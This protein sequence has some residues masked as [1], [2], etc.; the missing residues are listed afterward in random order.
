MS[1]ERTGELYEIFEGLPRVPRQTSPTSDKDTLPFYSLL[2]VLKP[3]FH[4]LETISREIRRAQRHVDSCVDE[5]HRLMDELAAPSLL[6]DVENELLIAEAELLSSTAAIEKV[7]ASIESSA[8]SAEDSA[9]EDDDDLGWGRL[10]RAIIRPGSSANHPRSREDRLKRQSATAIHHCLEVLNI[11]N[12]K[13]A[14]YRLRIAV[15]QEDISEYKRDIDFSA[16]VTNEFVVETASFDNLSES[17]AG[18]KEVKPVLFDQKGRHKKSVVEKT[19]AV[20]DRLRSHIV[21][22]RRRHGIDSGSTSE[23]EVPL[24]NHRSVHRSSAIDYRFTSS[25]EQ[26]LQHENQLLLSRQ[27]DAAASAAKEVESSARELSQLTSLVSEKALLQSEQISM[28]EQNVEH[29]VSN[30][31]NAR[32]QLKNPAVTSRWNP[33]RQLIVLLWI[34]ILVLITANWLVR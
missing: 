11:L 20:A 2:L 5:S 10:V 34:N 33:T 22:V 24:V 12:G 1:T 9:V 3:F 23:E 4:S 26:E 32:Q 31:E 21:G 25:E 13:A 28:L 29:A 18:A 7:K 14:H 30:T 16:G 6:R 19:K 27:M 17:F 8:N 15:C